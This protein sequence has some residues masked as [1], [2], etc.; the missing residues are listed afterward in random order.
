MT[1]SPLWPAS[2]GIGYDFT[3][4]PDDLSDLSYDEKGLR[5]PDRH[6][7]RLPGRS[8]RLPV[9]RV[10]RRV[11]FGRLDPDDRPRG[12]GPTRS[13]QQALQVQSRCWRPARDPSRSRARAPRRPLWAAPGS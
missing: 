7:P 8:R 4:D 1:G 3:D 9:R 10:G 5:E 2:T 11:E 6:V 12:D 13:G